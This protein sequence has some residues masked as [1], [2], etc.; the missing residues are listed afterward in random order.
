MIVHL[1]QQHHTSKP[2]LN[3]GTLRNNLKNN[4]IN[5]EETEFVSRVSNSGCTFFCSVFDGGGTTFNNLLNYPFIVLDIDNTK[6]KQILNIN[7]QARLDDVYN[8]FNNIGCPPFLAYHTFSNSPEC[9]KFRLVW[10]FEQPLNNLHIRTLVVKLIVEYFNLNNKPEALD[11]QASENATMFFYGTTTGPVVYNK[12]NYINLNLLFDAVSKSKKYTLSTTTQNKT[13]TQLYERFLKSLNIKDYNIY[14][15]NNNKL[16]YKLKYEYL[17][18]DLIIYTSFNNSVYKIILNTR[19]TKSKNNKI[20]NDTL[21]NSALNINN[22]QDLIN[23]LNNNISSNEL[24]DRKILKKVARHCE[25]AK[26]YLN[27]EYTKHN[28]RLVLYSFL[29]NFKN[30]GT[31][32]DK[33]LKSIGKNYDTNIK[34]FAKYLYSAMSCTKSDSC[35]KNHNLLYLYNKIKNDVIIKDEIECSS[36]QDLRIKLNDELD[37]ILNTPSTDNSIY[38]LNPG[39][40][41]G[42]TETLF[43]KTRNLDNF[44]FTFGTHNKKSDFKSRVA[45]DAFIQSDLPTLDQDDQ[46]IINNLCIQKKSYINHLKYIKNSNKY[47]TSVKNKI[48]DFINNFYKIHTSKKIYCT[49]EKLKYINDIN[50]YEGLIIFDEDCESMITNIKSINKSDLQLVMDLIKFKLHLIRD[51]TTK[52]YNVVRDKLNNLLK[53][54][55]E[56][57]TNDLYVVYNIKE[58]VNFDLYEL[59]NKDDL[60][61]IKIKNI[62]NQLSSP[63]FELFN[64]PFYIKNKDHNLLTGKLHDLPPN[65]K[66]IIL[67]ATPDLNL[68]YKLYGDR[69]KYIK[70]NKS[71]IKGSVLQKYNK[72]FTKKCINNNEEEELDYIYNLYNDLKADYIITFKKYKNDLINRGI[73]EHLIYNFGG[74]AGLN[75]MQGRDVLVAGTFNPPLDHIKLKAKIVYGVDIKNDGPGYL[76]MSQQLVNHDSVTFRYYTYNDPIARDIHLHFTWDHAVQAIG[77]ARV[78]DNDCNVYLLSNFILYEAVQLKEQTSIKEGLFK[79]RTIKKYKN[80][81]SKEQEMYIKKC[82]DDLNIDYNN[83]YIQNSL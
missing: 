62:L 37:Y 76:K 82:T 36:L 11:A 50:N 27:N 79:L 32:C 51:E 45:S 8:Q 56:I 30:G 38:I 40:G 81:L 2:H 70:F 60:N 52:K 47:K 6:D 33:H 72:S 42:K 17:G 48:N 73:P 31:L 77:R 14:T 59:F 58:E 46:V 19:S 64:N 12:N 75:N 83:V 25:L 23:H 63:V 66:I 28:D 21:V 3:I 9:E 35:S 53:F 78:V 43:K 18:D 1:E 54:L 15:K 24:L 13:G 80:D 44:I 68:Y 61:N 4:L 74:V 65:A 5:I 71:Y 67:S 22:K 39:T 55:G 10:K 69:V 7:D 57:Y 34:S 49:H 29:L 41:V 26:K 16:N 20:K